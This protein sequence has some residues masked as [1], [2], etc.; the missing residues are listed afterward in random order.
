MEDLDK[1]ESVG[2][3]IEFEE[4]GKVKLEVLIDDENIGI[5]EE[6]EGVVKLGLG[7]CVEAVP[8][9]L[10]TD[11][12]LNTDELVGGLTT[13]FGGDEVLGVLDRI[14]ELEDGVIMLTGG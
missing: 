14:E 12:E 11:I 7:D 2:V 10:E 9:G 3:G 6:L 5:A 4:L 1:G 8:D 13:R